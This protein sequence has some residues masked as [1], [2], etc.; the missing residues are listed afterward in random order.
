M[1]PYKYI[2]QLNKYG[3]KGGFKPG[4]ER[5]NLVLE[6]FDHP[7]NKLK[8]IHVGGSNGK[9]STIA[10][11]RSIYQL[12]GYKVGAYISPPI[13]S[14]NERITINNEPISTE[15]LEEIINDLDS[16]IKELMYKNKIEKPSFFEFI[17]AVAYI[18]FYRKKVDIA[19]MEVGL[20]GRLDATNIVSFPL[21]SVITSI[22]LEHSVILGNSRTQI[23][24][25]KAGI[26]KEGRPIITGVKNEQAFRVIKKIARIKGAPFIDIYNRYKYELKSTSLAGQEV[27]VKSYRHTRKLNIP[28]LG[29]HQIINALLA[30]GVVEELNG[31]LPVREG[32]IIV[33]IN[34]TSWPG[35]MEIVRQHPFV[36]IDGAHNSEGMEMMADFLQQNFN[37]GQNIYIVLG[38]LNDK[39]VREMLGCLHIN[40]FNIK[41]YITRSKSKRA[42]KPEEIK[43]I[44]EEIHVEN[45]I[46]NRLEEAI[47]NVMEDA[48]ED[49]LIIITGSLYTVRE[50][51]FYFTD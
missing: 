21:I 33:G 25:E 45:K 1:D 24:Y 44:A 41:F 39:N 3:E 28:L 6:Q 23:A 5:I 26:I 9:G 42:L 2:D 15:D 17:T 18:F 16:V 36:I 8:V 34:E 32:H 10:F 7:E 43:K 46:F 37:R 47:I 49:D 29:R 30:L 22:S 12:A 38:I 20:G 11:L 35:R 14:F 19:L 13:F 51:K 27:L 31:L 4:L 48:G 40:K 50:A